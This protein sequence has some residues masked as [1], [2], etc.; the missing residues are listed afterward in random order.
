MSGPAGPAMPRA[1][2]CPPSADGKERPREAACLLRVTQQHPKAGFEARSALHRR[3]QFLL[4]VLPHQQIK[5]EV[6]ELVR[7]VRF[8]EA[9]SQ[10]FSSISKILCPSS[11]LS[12]TV[13]E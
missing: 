13:F 11:A 8:G 5:C 7:L 1:D 3:P 2:R 9:L 4:L 10:K 6:F 12:V